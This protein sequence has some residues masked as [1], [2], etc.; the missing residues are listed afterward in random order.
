MLNLYRIFKMIYKAMKML[1]T[2]NEDGNL[3]IYSGVESEKYFF[4]VVSK[5]VCEKYRFSP[6]IQF[7]QYVENED[8]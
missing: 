5:E 2:V 1:N 3:E 7:I 6:E 4:F 8:E